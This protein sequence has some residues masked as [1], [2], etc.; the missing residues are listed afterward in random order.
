MILKVD[1][2]NNA[3]NSIRRDMFLAATRERAQA[4]YKLLRQVYSGPTSIFIGNT[5]LVSSIGIQQEDPF[6]P[7]LFSLGI[8]NIAR[9][10]ETE[11]NVWYLDDGTLEDSPDKVLAVATKLVDD[12]REVGL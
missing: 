2:A 9:G 4:L 12:L 3:C 8:D 10:L 5:N 6:L 1:V 7:A 11:F